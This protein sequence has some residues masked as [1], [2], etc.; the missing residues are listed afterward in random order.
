MGTH[1]ETKEVVDKLLVS[2]D[3][4]IDSANKIRKF[5]R[6]AKFFDIGVSLGCILLGLRLSWDYEINFSWILFCIGFF[7]FCLSLHESYLEKCQNKLLSYLMM[8]RVNIIDLRQTVES[9]DIIRSRTESWIAGLKNSVK[10]AHLLC[11]DKSVFLIIVYESGCSAIPKKVSAIEKELYKED[12]DVNLHI[13]CAPSDGNFKVPNEVL[14]PDSL[15]FAF[16]KDPPSWVLV[17]EN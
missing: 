11:K 16:E 1:L 10:S 8:S 6:I 5:C 9:R 7:A 17:K 2:S 4:D 14:S 13:L 15:R 3:C 12:L